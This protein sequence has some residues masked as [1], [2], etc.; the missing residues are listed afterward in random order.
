[1]ARHR[2]RCLL[3]L[4]DRHRSATRPAFPLPG[5]RFESYRQGS[6][7]RGLAP[8]G[9]PY[10]RAL[11]RVRD[12]LSSLGLVPLRGRLRPTLA[13]WRARMAPCA[14]VAPPLRTVAACVRP[15]P[16]WWRRR[17]PCRVPCLRVRGPGEPGKPNRKPDANAWFQSGLH[18]PE[19]MPQRPV[20]IPLLRHVAMAASASRR[21]T[22]AP[23]SRVDRGPFPPRA[24]FFRRPSVAH[25]ARRGPEV[26]AL[27]EGVTPGPAPRGIDPGDPGSPGLRGG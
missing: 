17:A 16:P 24:V 27:R 9:G 6:V 14:T 21:V 23:P 12:G 22:P 11:L 25:A 7:P 5:L 3:G 20:A 18:Q 26:R 13:G 2:A 10:H 4:R 1:V 8:R 15:R 19:L